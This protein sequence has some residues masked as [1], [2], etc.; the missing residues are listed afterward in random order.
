MFVWLPIILFVRVDFAILLY[1]ERRKFV[2]QQVWSFKG[3][4]YLVTCSF[5]P[6]IKQVCNY[7][8][9]T[10]QIIIVITISI[11]S[12]ILKNRQLQDKTKVDSKF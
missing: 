6:I 11:Q 12:S 4:S 1:V 2:Y 10:I 8:D 3:T 5:I 9:N 7:F